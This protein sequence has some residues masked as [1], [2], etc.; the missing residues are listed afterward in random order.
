MMPVGLLDLDLSPRQGLEFDE[1]GSHLV[2]LVAVEA[3]PTE[4][5]V[6]IQLL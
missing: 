6:K 5:P 4:R 1:L 3:T 2:Q